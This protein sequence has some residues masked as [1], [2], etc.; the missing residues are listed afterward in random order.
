MK[1]FFLPILLGLCFC[2]PAQAM[3]MIVE[4]LHPRQIRLNQEP[5][6]VQTGALAIIRSKVN[7]EILGY[8]KYMGADR[9]ELVLHEHSPLIF[10]GDFVEFPDLTSG[11]DDFPGR[12]DLLVMGNRH[13]AARYKYISY[14]GVIIGEGHSLDKKEWQ[15]DLT[16]NVAYGIT[17]RWTVG[18]W[19]VVDIT[20]PN[21]MTKYT[22]V[23]SGGIL[24]TPAYKY[25]FDRKSDSVTHIFSA[26]LTVGSN[27]KIMSHTVA[28]GTLSR[29][30]DKST[31]QK[32]FFKSDLSSYMEWILPNWDRVLLGPV[33][34]LEK[35]KI[36]GLFAY[37]WIWTIFQMS[38]NLQTREVTNAKLDFNRGYTVYSTFL[39]RW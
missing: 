13:I 30:G 24:L 35:K 11:V 15:V 25:I 18:T 16:G 34:D 39:W 14:Y 22:V 12:A 10:V 9:V 17:N 33:Y 6:D 5:H 21:F 20:S 8:G 32:N 31:I 2:V 37:Y 3:E 26:R 7:D 36:G 1:H 4:L 23:N 27:S 29:L 19:A 28:Q 38:L